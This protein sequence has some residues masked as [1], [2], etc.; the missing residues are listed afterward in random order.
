MVCNRLGPGRP[1]GL[2]EGA[3]PDRSC[4]YVEAEDMGVTGLVR[5]YRL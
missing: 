2:F 1:I 5:G 4:A 3:G